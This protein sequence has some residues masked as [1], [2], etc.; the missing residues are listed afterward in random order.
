S[1]STEHLVHD[2]E[3]LRVQGPLNWRVGRLGMYTEGRQGSVARIVSAPHWILLLAAASPLLAA[4]ARAMRRRRRR[5]HGR[6]AE[7]GHERGKGRRNETDPCPECGT[8]LQA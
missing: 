2:H 8:A 4:E 6:C 3:R 7:C 1:A 5:R